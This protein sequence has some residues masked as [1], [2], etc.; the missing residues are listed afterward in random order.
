MLGTKNVLIAEYYFTDDNGSLASEDT[1]REFIRLL[2]RD[3]TYPGD[4]ERIGQL[5][6]L[7]PLLW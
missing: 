4:V 2:L 7:S 6:P 1:C 3:F 5:Q